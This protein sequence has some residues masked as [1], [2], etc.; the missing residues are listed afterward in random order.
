MLDH[1][2]MGIHYTCHTRALKDGSCHNRTSKSGVEVKICGCN[3]PD[4]CNFSM[5]P[6][7]PAKASQQVQHEDDDQEDGVNGSYDSILNYGFILFAS[8]IF[9]FF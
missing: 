1:P 3:G 7:K 6:D 9:N 8:C 4:F 2:R 5:W